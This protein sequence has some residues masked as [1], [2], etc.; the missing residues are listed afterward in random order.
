MTT[1]IRISECSRFGG[2]FDFP[3]LRQGLTVAL[4]IHGL[5]F[6]AFLLT[7]YHAQTSQV[8]LTEI[9]LVDQI[10]P[11]PEPVSPTHPS[12]IPAVKEFNLFDL[13]H[14]PKSLN[15]MPSQLNSMPSLPSLPKAQSAASEPKA[16]N[17]NQKTALAIPGENGIALD[18]VGK[19]RAAGPGT[20]DVPKDLIKPRDNALSTSVPSTAGVVA[21]QGKANGFSMSGPITQRI[22]IG[23]PS[24]QARG[25]RLADLP[26]IT[27]PRDTKAAAVEQS[28][29]ISSPNQRG[30]QIYGELQ[31]R[32]ITKKVLPPYP[33]WAEEEN[34]CG[35]VRIRFWV[36]PDGK[37]KDN[38]LIETSS[39]WSEIDTLAAKSLKEFV[40]APLTGSQEQEG[41][42]EFYFRL[43]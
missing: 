37:V 16:L 11:I 3:G 43:D 1:T 19:K 26:R 25:G 15:P 18:L 32:P 24:L 30:F 2:D 40:F 28:K 29:P 23:R 20:L 7:S 10:I 9:T 41:V 12:P 6:I 34:W 35:A 36:L 17:I 22:S 38:L 14:P 33:R 31:N 42:I 39:G 21:L 8:V 27:K 13:I 4:V 5:L